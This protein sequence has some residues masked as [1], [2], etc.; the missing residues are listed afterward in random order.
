MNIKYLSEPY[1]CPKCD[2]DGIQGGSVTI[3]SGVATQE[4]WCPACGFGWDDIY[5]LWSIAER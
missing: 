1:R 3:E 4:M 2:D 5:K